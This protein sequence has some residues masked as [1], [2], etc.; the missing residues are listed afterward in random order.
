VITFAPVKHLTGTLSALIILIGGAHANAAGP[1]DRV[2]WLQGC[3]Q[4]TSSSRVVEEQWTA[5]RG[6]IMLG[7][8]RTT[9]D[10]RL[11]EYEFVVLSEKEGQLAY[12]A[13]PTGQATAVFMATAVSEAAVVF[14]NATHDFPQ[15]VAYQKQGADGLLASVEGT[16]GGRS[17]RIEF[18]YQRVRCDQSPNAP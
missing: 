10:G 3:W 17:R 9:R 14:E 13:H 2:G 18:A 5:P 11:I 15:R 7:V 1:I 16:V 12:E 4:T 8:G 6:G